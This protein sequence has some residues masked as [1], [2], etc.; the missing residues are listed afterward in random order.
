MFN[1]NTVDSIYFVRVAVGESLSDESVLTRGN[2][3]L[4]LTILNS[5][6]RELDC[7]ARELICKKRPVGNS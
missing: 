1:P 2:L 3:L 7:I 5:D 4:T 6:T